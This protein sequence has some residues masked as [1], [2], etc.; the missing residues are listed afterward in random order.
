MKNTLKSLRKPENITLVLAVAISLGFLVFDIIQPVPGFVP[1]A[2]LSVLGV[3]AFAML[4]ERLGYFERFE[5]ALRDIKQEKG[6]F[7]QVRTGW[8][9]F[10]KYARDAREISV[11]GG[12]LAQL[13]PRYGSSLSGRPGLGASFDSFCLIPTVL[14]WKLWRDGRRR[15]P[16]G[17]KWRLGFR[18]HT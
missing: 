16:I 17:S 8:V 12:S 9:P 13:V 4:A 11:S 18:F 15:L 6:P 3:L 5:Q 2:T 7:L 14:R 1:K 10:E